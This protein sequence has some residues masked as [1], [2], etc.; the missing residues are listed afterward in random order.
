MTAAAESFNLVTDGQSV[1]LMDNLR[2]TEHAGTHGAGCVKAPGNGL[3]R[4]QTR[5]LQLQHS[6][7][8]VL[9]L[10]EDKPR[11]QGLRGNRTQTQ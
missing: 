11:E 5:T 4:L 2:E 3:I 9:N 8:T 1:R 10:K 7:L 6:P